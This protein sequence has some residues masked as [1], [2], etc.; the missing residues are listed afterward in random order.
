MKKRAVDKKA[1]IRIK[2]SDDPASAPAFRGNRF[3]FGRAP[4]QPPDSNGRLERSVGNQAA[5]RLLALGTSVKTYEKAKECADDRVMHRGG[6]ETESQTGNTGN[7]GRPLPPV[8]RPGATQAL[9]PSNIAITALCAVTHPVGIKN[10][11]SGGFLSYGSDFTHQLSLSGGGIAS[12]LKGTEVTE[13]IV[14]NRDDFKLTQTVGKNTGSIA[15]GKTVWVLGVKGSSRPD[16][17]TDRIETPDLLILNSMEKHKPRLPAKREE[18][19]SFYWRRNAND[20]W[21]P[22]A[23]VKIHFMV[24]EYHKKLLTWTIDNSV[25]VAENWSGRRP[26]GY[27]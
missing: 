3:S 26:R 14:I 25:V 6:P 22:F 13:K 23:T 27:Y 7:E 15:M 8:E 20:Q 16:R 11:S 4:H 10:T 21:H 1:Y 17:F 2:N 18:T 5:H 24:D 12:C 19:Q 9:S